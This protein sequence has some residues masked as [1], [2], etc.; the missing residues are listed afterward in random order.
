MNTKL[1]IS[2]GF[3]IDDVYFGFHEGVLYQLPYINSGKYFGLRKLR[4]KKLKKNGWEYYVTDRKF[5]T[6]IIQCVV[7]GYETEMGDVYM[8]ELK[9][10][11]ASR[12]KDL[13]ELAPCEGWEWIA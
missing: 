6:D 5:D 1:H 12:T 4:K 11:I 8:S 7:M 9:G 2:L 10:H 13:S 3:K